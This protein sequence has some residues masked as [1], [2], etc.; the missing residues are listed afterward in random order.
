MEATR[1]LNGSLRELAYRESDGI[2]VTLIWNEREDTLTV[3]VLDARKGDSFELDAP[4]DQALDVFY[5]PYSHAAHRGVRD[6][7]RSVRDGS[8]S[9]SFSKPNEAL[10]RAA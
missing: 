1:T 9:S 6:A 3:S 10:R 2:E 4:R 5:H 8:E 7:E